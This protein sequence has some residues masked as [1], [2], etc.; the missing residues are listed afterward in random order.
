MNGTS[1]TTGNSEDRRL[2]RSALPALCLIVYLALALFR[3]S[4]MPHPDADEAWFAN[5]ALNLLTEGNFG[6]STLAGF[7]GFDHAT[8][9]VPPLQS[10]A[11]VLPI[12][13]FG[14]HLW[15]VRLMSVLWGF[16]T[17]LALYRT[18][19]LLAMGRGAASLFLLLL[20]T[21]FTFLSLSRFARAEAL[22]T[23]L[24]SAMLLCLVKSAMTKR[25]SM[26]AA[27]GVFAGLSFLTHPLAVFSI[28]AFLVFFTP[29]RESSGGAIAWKVWLKDA[30]TF[31]GM[32]CITWVPYLFYVIHEGWH[33]L[34]MQAV[35]YK[36]YTYRFGGAHGW[37][38]AHFL[39]VLTDWSASRERMFFALKIIALTWLAWPPGKMKR[40]FTLSAIQFVTMALLWPR[41]DWYYWVSGFY[42]T[43]VLCAAG[44]KLSRTDSWRIVPP[45]AA[46]MAT[47]VFVSGFI[48]L[49]L[50]AYWHALRRP[51]SN[52]P[53]KLYA[54]LRNIIGDP[55]GGNHKILGDVSLLFALPKPDYDLRC[56]FVVR[57][58]M[59]VAGKSW[60]Q[61]LSE[62]SPN[63]ILLDSF[64]A[65]GEYDAFYVPPDGIR[66]FL[67]RNATLLGT[68][69]AN[70][71]WTLGYIEVYRIDPRVFKD[72]EL[73]PRNGAISP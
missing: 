18:G 15:S 37:P 35:V 61:A 70:P 71:N 62:I 46:R 3:I 34:W 47:T 48:A 1:N 22:L 44:G 39:A 25:R 11:L 10:L 12:K 49:N 32:I 7:L 4:Q 14:L 21:D 9:W 59:D 23:F 20:G 33:E 26:L 41:I 24:Q 57:S 8:F 29:R 36:A 45:R 51:W 6:S 67:R 19:R 16:L 2:L 31:G 65:T 58:E 50:F 28:P 5:P 66:S 17:L 69:R 30:L 42:V 72:P 56:Y 27:A 52:H 73:R 38:L 64:F 43:L 40:L 54:Q 60:R 53:E 13:L 63:V 68:V 55:H